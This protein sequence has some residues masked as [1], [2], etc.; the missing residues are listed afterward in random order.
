MGSKNAYFHL[1]IKNDGTYLKIYDAEPG[2]QPLVYD[3]ISNYLIDRK[4][5]EYDK[6][7]LGRAIAT[8][9]DTAEVKL[10]TANLLPQDE[11]LKVV[12]SE[13]RM[14]VKGRFYAPSNNGNLMTKEDIIQAMVRAGVKYGVDEVNVYSFLHD[15]KYCTDYILAKAT[16]AVQGRDAVISYHFNT[17]LTLKPKTNEDGSVDFHQLDMISHCKK[18]ELLATLTPV[19]YG[20]PG[21]DVCGNIIR[22]N[23][24]NN[25]ILRHGNKVYLSEDGLQMYSEVDGHVT[26][27]DGRVFVS[28]VYEIPA[29]VDTSTG[30]VEYDGNVVIKG[31]VIT[32]FSVKAKGNIEVNGVVEGAYLEAGGQIVLKRGMQGM[33]KGILKA[34]GNIITKFLENAEV[35]AGGY[36]T[37]ESILHSKVSA[38]GDVIVGGRRGFVTGGEI[39]SGS[40][41]SVKTAGSQM[42]TNTLLEVGIDPRVLEEFRELEK[43]IATLQSDKDKLAQAVAMIRKKMQMGTQIA[44]DKLDNLKQITQSNVYIDAQLQE[45]RKRYDELKLEVDS[46]SSGAIKIQDI[47]YPGTKIVIS[48]VIYFVREEIHHS[49]FIRDRADIKVVAL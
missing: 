13:D 3:E 18:D 19:D 8:L 14:F 11:Y 6:V 28:D 24:V 1:T 17:D 2:G 30:D 5:Y 43:K 35:I 38:K 9:K 36:V 23:K 37:T 20:K 4:I 27:T 15:R 39:R 34:N 29:D 32:G 46:N 22:P 47:V 33:N 49:R 21:I 45:A 41:I 10:T 26:L 25:R 48:N 40:L 12:I 42:G 16:P 31:N 44:Q 7:E